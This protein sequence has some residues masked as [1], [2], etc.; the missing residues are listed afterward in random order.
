MA[1]FFFGTLKDRDVLALVIGRRIDDADVE[2]AVLAGYRLARVV[3]D[4]YPAPLPHDGAR[5]EGILVRGLTPAEVERLAWFEG[6]EYAP[7][8]VE[9]ELPGGGT[10]EALIQAPTEVL[11]IVG[12]DWDVE[13]WRRDEKDLLM[14]L[15]R[16]HMALYGRAS[17]DEAIRIW[18][19]TREKL[20]A[21]PAEKLSRKG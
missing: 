16:G 13:A 18:D 19:E 9:V 21:E 6:K 7:D 5:I 10:A 14:T 12:E 20:L 8:T 4:P 1:H 3:D 15:T 17:L 11:E 2:G